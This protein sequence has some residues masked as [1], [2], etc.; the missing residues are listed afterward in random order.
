MTT[1]LSV[2]ISSYGHLRWKDLAYNHAYPSTVGQ[3]FHEV[4]VLHEENMTLAEVR[5]A[6][7]AR[8]TGEYLCYLDADDTLDA[9]FNQAME[10]A[11]SGLKKNAKVLLSPSVKYSNSRNPPSIWPQ[12]DI[13]DGNWMIIGTVLPRKLF[14]R[15]GGF[16]KYGLY[17]DWAL[18]G[19]CMKDGAVPHEVPDAVYL[20][21]ASSRSRNRSKPRPE[22]NY[23]HQE[24]GHDNWPD[25]YPPPTEEER[26]RRALMGNVR[27]TP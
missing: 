10:V 22:M 26:K 7:A 9:G 16:D 18:W 13:K 20:A 11:I 24:I 8:A 27:K 19:K 17:E 14:L 15:V 1:T 4:L 6:N 2:L 3:G 23:W 12:M 5:N 25:Y 21:V